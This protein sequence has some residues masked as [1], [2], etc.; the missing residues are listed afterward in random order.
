VSSVISDLEREQA[1]FPAAERIRDGFEV[2]IIGAPNAGKSTLL[3]RLA[4]RE[5]ALTS[6][7]AGTTRDVI[8]VRMDL[9][10]L[11]VTLLDTAGLRE[12]C[13]PVEVMGIARARE[14]ALAAD[15]RI[16]LV[17]PGDPQTDVEL[18]ADDLV[19]HGKADLFPDAAAPA[20]SGVTGEGIDALV[21]RI[22]EILQRRTASTVTISRLRHKVAV[23]K[24]IRNLWQAL[25]VLSKGGNEELMAESL[26][27]AIDGMDD[28]VGRIGIEDL[29]GEI[30][31]SFCIGK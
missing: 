9:G 1:G 10:G 18:V 4:G 8:E 22:G 23:D 3:N 27:C 7:H 2:A 28:L 25:D 12:A 20:V 21:E 11:P 26:R 6:E 16:Y 13:D 14:R 19:V 15:L 17:A 31:S 30:F 5:A 24:A 29:L